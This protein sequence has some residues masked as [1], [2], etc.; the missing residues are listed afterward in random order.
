MKTT[1]TKGIYVIH[2]IHYIDLQEG[3]ELAYPDSYTKEKFAGK[4]A[5]KRKYP[6]LDTGDEP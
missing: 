3:L 5:A 2:G 4:S 6:N 1:K